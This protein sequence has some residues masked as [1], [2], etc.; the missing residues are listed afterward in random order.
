MCE[1]WVCARTIDAHK[2]GFV[3]L[4]MFLQQNE[5]CCMLSV[6]MWPTLCYLFL[7][8]LLFPNKMYVEYGIKIGSKLS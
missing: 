3:L 1:A 6:K 4:A 2:G 5:H 7:S 8:L